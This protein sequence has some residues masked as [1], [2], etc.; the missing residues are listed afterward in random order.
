MTRPHVPLKFQ[1]EGE[2]QKGGRVP[3]PPLRLPA[4][5]LLPKCA[6]SIEV[7]CFT[8]W[9]RREKVRGVCRREGA[10]W[11]D[12]HLAAGGRRGYGAE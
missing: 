4:C 11:E 1:R 3:A 5:S 6:V 2:E 8:A 12:P 9:G 7:R 10:C